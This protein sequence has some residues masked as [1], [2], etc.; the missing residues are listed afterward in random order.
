MQDLRKKKYLLFASH[1]STDSMSLESHYFSNKNQTWLMEKPKE[2]ADDDSDDDA[3]QRPV[4]KKLS[5]MIIPSL[6][7]EKGN[8]KIS[9]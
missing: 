6:I 2:L 1:I 5:G 8:L 4:W 7:T 9:Y 3:Q